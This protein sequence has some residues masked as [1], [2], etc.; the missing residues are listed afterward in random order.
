MMAV[1]Q[2][3]TCLNDVR[4]P[5]ELFGS[6][7]R[8]PICLSEFVAPERVAKLQTEDPS[9][10]EDADRLKNEPES[11]EKALSGSASSKHLSCP[12]CGCTEEPTITKRISQAGW[13]VFAVLLVTFWPLFWI[14]LLINEEV[15]Q[16]RRCRRYIATV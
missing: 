15:R 12:S 5:Q 7:V 2:C 10:Q 11:S 16:C 6:L 14:G 1:W 9:M 13:I 8:C 4:I 3:P